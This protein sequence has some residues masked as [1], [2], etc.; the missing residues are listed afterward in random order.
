MRRA[1]CTSQRTESSR[2]FLNSPFRLLEKVTR[3]LLLFSIRLSSTFFPNF[4]FYPF[5]M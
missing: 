2:A 1:I 3:R 4:E 5:L